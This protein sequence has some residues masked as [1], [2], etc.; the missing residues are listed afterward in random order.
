[1]ALFKQYNILSK[2]VAADESQKTTYDDVASKIFPKAAS[3]SCE[4]M[5]QENTDP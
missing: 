2:Q 1:M 5:N 3:P 4:E